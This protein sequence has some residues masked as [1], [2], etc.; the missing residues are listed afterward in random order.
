[1][2]DRAL[3]SLSLDLILEE[4]QFLLSVL[5]LLGSLF[6]IV[7]FGIKFLHFLSQ[8]VLQLL[9]SGL[10]SQ[11]FIPFALKLILD[12]TN[13]ALQRGLSSLV[14]VDEA[15]LVIDELFQFL[16]DALISRALS[17]FLLDL[18]PQEANGLS[19]VFFLLG[20]E[21]CL[22]TQLVGKL[23][24]LVQNLLDLLDSSFIDHA[25]TPLVINGFSQGLDFLIVLHADPII[26]ENLFFPFT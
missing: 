11:G 15:G 4:V 22:T 24:F 8:Q 20:I 21:L 5:N 18:V 25:F 13:L 9:D 17:A 14:L 2:I 3:S 1:L 26:L 6:E 10:V 19:I 23:Y 12:S 7:V 16:N